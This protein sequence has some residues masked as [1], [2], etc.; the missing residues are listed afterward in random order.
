MSRD[1]LLINLELEAKGFKTELKQTQKALD[2]NDRQA[3]AL[4][5]AIRDLEKSFGNVAKQVKSTDKELMN[6]QQI[7][8]DNTAVYLEAAEAASSLG[9]VYEGVA[10]TLKSLGSAF[11]SIAETSSDLFVVFEK[12]TDP[13]FLV[14]LARIFLILGAL[15][16]AKGYGGLADELTKV[17]SALEKSAVMFSQFREEG[18]FSIETLASRIRILNEFRDAA[19]KAAAMVGFLTLLGVITGVNDVLVEFGVVSRSVST[20]LSKMPAFVQSVTVPFYSLW[21]AVKVA[22]NSWNTFRATLLAISSGNKPFTAF[23]KEIPG[24]MTAVKASTDELGKSVKNVSKAFAAAVSSVSAGLTNLR[25]AGSLLSGAAS[26]AVAGFNQDFSRMILSSEAPY[27]AFEKVALT[28]GQRFS[29]ALEGA[30]SSELGAG[31]KKVYVGIEKD[32]NSFGSGTSSVLAKAG[33]GI[34][35]EIS[36]ISTDISKAADGK[37]ASNLEKLGERMA[38]SVGGKAFKEALKELG[39]EFKF[40]MEDISDLINA[41]TLRMVK[42]FNDNFSGLGQAVSSLLSKALGPQK[43][44]AINTSIQRLSSLMSFHTANMSK[45]LTVLGRS[46]A[47][48]SKDLLG[49]PAAL[50]FP[51]IKAY[52]TGLLNQAN[53]VVFSAIAMHRNFIEASIGLGQFSAALAKEG[54]PKLRQYLQLIL[55][56]KEGLVKFIG[57]TGSMTEG[58]MTLAS[59]LKKSAMPSFILFMT[60]LQGVGYVL[61]PVGI[62]VDVYRQVIKNLI[63]GLDNAVMSS[64]ML[65]SQLVIL[66]KASSVFAK[67]FSAAASVVGSTFPAAIKGVGKSISL[68][69]GGGFKIASASLKAFSMSASESA[70]GVVSAFSS[71]SETISLIMSTIGRIVKIGFNSASEPILIFGIKAAE[72]FKSLPSVVSK[73]MLRIGGATLDAF[74]ILD[75]AIRSTVG[76]VD[77]LKISL[78]PLAKEIS[79]AAREISSSFSKALSFSATFFDDIAFGFKAITTAKSFTEFAIIMSYSLKSAFT[80]A[81]NVIAMNMEDIGNILSTRGVQAAKM[82]AAA[83]SELAKSFG[84]TVSNMLTTTLSWESAIVKSVSGA[85]DAISRGSKAFVNGF[86]VGFTAPIATAA[87]GLKGFGAT[88]KTIAPGLLPLAEA[89]LFVG[90]PLLAIGA[91]AISSESKL[92]KLGGAAAI[93][94]GIALSGLSAAILFS[95]NAVGKFTEAIGDK[96]L[97]AMEGFEQKFR[98]GEIVTK[99]FAFTVANFGKTL[100]EQAVGSLAMWEEKVSSIAKTTTL[101]GGAVRKAVQLIIAEGQALGLTVTQ[102]SQLLE[103]AVDLAV[104]KDMEL[105]DVVNRLMSGI[106]GMSQSVLSLGIN[107]NQHAIEHSKFTKQ[108]EEEGVELSETTDMLVRFNE[109]M[110]QTIP[111]AGFAAAAVDTISGATAQYNKAL[112]E[113]QEAL[114]KQ[115]DFTV[116]Y[117]TTLTN[118]SKAFLNLP[119]SIIELSGSLIDVGGVVAKVGGLFLQYVLAVSSA[120]TITTVLNSLLLGAPAV[121]A[122]MSSGF[123]LAAKGLNIQTIAVTGL[124]SVFQNLIL[125]MKGSLVRAVQ[126]LG[127]V[128]LTLTKQFLALTWAVVTNPLFLKGT[129]IV[130]TIFAL[131]QAFKEL[132]EELGLFG[133][134]SK[135]AGDAASAFDPFAEVVGFLNRAFQGLVNAVKLVLIGIAKLIVVSKMAGAGFKMMAHDLLGIGKAVDSN[136]LGESLDALESLDNAVIKIIGSGTAMAE[137][138]EQGLDSVKKSADAAAKS[139]KSLPTNL[140]EEIRIDVMGTDAEKAA[141]KVD[142]LFATLINMQKVG[143]IKV[144][145]EVLMPTEDN[146]RKMREGL[147]NKGSDKAAFSKAGAADI[148]ELSAELRAAQLESIKLRKSGIKEVQEML[149]TLN[150]KELET[151]GRAI[152]AIRLKGAEEL[153]ILNDKKLQQE[154][155]G[156]LTDLDIQRYKNLTA[157]IKKSTEIEVLAKQK[158]QLEQFVSEMKTVTDEN[159]KLAQELAGVADASTLGLDMR[160]AAQLKVLEAKSK[161][162]SESNKYNGEQKS[163]LEEQIALQ[164]KLLKVITDRTKREILSAKELSRLQKAADSSK[165]KEASASVN[166]FIGGEGETREVAGPP[167][168]G[169]DAP[170][171]FLPPSALSSLAGSVSGFMA[172]AD[173]IAGFVQKLIDWL[174]EF[175]DKVA[176]IFESLEALPARLIKS[177][178]NLGKSFLSFVKNFIANIFK[179]F[180]EGLDSLLPD[181]FN[182][183]GDMFSNIGDSIEDLMINKMPK[184]FEKG[185]GGAFIKAFARM[186]GMLGRM[187]SVIFKSIVKAFPLMIKAF[188]SGMGNALKTLANEISRIFGGKRLFKLPDDTE[189]KLKNMGK[190]IGKANDQLFKV[191]DLEAE[192]KAAKLATILNP[193][194]IGR[195][196]WESIKRAFMLA[197]DFFNQLGSMIWMG[198]FQPVVD[199]FKRKGAEIWEGFLEPIA[200]WFGDRGTEVWNGF[201]KPIGNWFGDM[202]TKLWDGFVNGMNTFR[203]TIGG[204]LTKVGNTF[205]SALESMPAKLQGAFDALKPSNLM[206]KVF[207]IDYK[208]MGDLENKVLKLD[209]PWSKFARGGIVGGAVSK[210]AGDS[211]LNDVVPA[212]LSVGEAVIPKSLMGNPAINSVIEGIL[213]GKLTSLEDMAELILGPLKEGLAGLMSNPVQFNQGGM[214]G[215]PKMAMASAM[216]G[217][218]TSISNNF[219]FN[220]TLDIDASATSL[221]ASFV[222][223]KLIPDIKKELKDSSLR[224]E[225]L[226]SNRGLR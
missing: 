18:K 71:V 29:G 2:E 98:S 5:K 161:E 55:N 110:S 15:A 132:R 62:L 165:G 201:L 125:I 176:K 133:E 143:V 122:A 101:S 181:L 72:V 151:N 158:E 109:I 10:G 78:S 154:L 91:A 182:A 202:G 8:R 190:T 174:P 141:K 170:T 185:I 49:I 81:K 12:L 159:A 180:G 192:A 35:K 23:V 144:G 13:E 117:I 77:A 208:G 11:S 44:E 37:I 223:N 108:L 135:A 148:E 153:K 178:K 217:G 163:A 20:T 73:S 187:L 87:A 145:T 65:K 83:F 113:V 218:S 197:R 118:L 63:Y 196:I 99:A 166:R 200:T 32:F 157:A 105:S 70:Y 213:S 104:A 45:D 89:G 9:K 58:L 24:L 36:L 147:L 95:L 90:P 152:E 69:F 173:A 43:M 93:V 172:A 203:D 221:D 164:Q 60:A 88:V 114:G 179:N 57:L 124:A 142:T 150:M 160:L 54:I 155:L 183:I 39:F 219:S 75:A 207:K 220:I 167:A 96:L 16:R 171:Q 168:P 210:L 28:S 206:E 128:L 121:Q 214:V 216:S 74:P 129:I 67:D 30:L 225:F 68:V 86:A 162:F 126:S 56:S 195:S 27:V 115:G 41:G 19:E 1:D 85:A 199:W 127:G 212:M 139:L 136:A 31:L 76:A 48:A 26:S 6:N 138:M 149:A 66:G 106:S 33:K 193:E 107:I 119:S 215:G 224:G 209:V 46:A 146:I 79:Y 226:L 116:W 140:A 211:P 40:V 112:T 169:Q 103:R 51:G 222:R 84:S 25:K 186:F 3:L 123:A 14:K 82:G 42:V 120:V 198:F 205:A 156:N 111:Q 21:E 134:S 100:G 59:A 188:I 50:A 53:A 191:M 38:G 52:F 97:A 175:L 184:M 80:L 102:S 4:E 47:L 177:F 130:A 137:E 131:I 64:R 189:D 22:N 7:M 34:S 17:S 94:A 194:R 204:V 92:T 61:R